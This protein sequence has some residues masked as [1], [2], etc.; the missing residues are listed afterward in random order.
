MKVGDREFVAVYRTKTTYVDAF[1]QC[2]K[3]N[4]RLATVSCQTELDALR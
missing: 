2:K 1:A 3:K 4:M